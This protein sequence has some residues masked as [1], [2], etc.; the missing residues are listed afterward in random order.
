MAIFGWN[1]GPIRGASHVSSGTPC[2]DSVC[3]ACAPDYCIAAVSDG[4]GGKRYF[5]SNIGSRFAVNIAVDLIKS[6]FESSGDFVKSLSFSPDSILG[7]LEKEILQTWFQTVEDYDRDHPL[8]EDEY[9]YAEANDLLADEPIKR[10]GCTL[11]VSVLV[12]SYSFSL[13]I[14]DGDILALYPDGSVNMPVPTDPRCHDNVTTSMCGSTASE[15]F[16]HIFLSENLPAGIMLSSD[17][18]STSFSSES[19]FLKYG[20]NA[21]V[22]CVKNL[23]QNLREDLVRRSTIVNCDDVSCAILWNPDMTVKAVNDV[24]SEYSGYFSHLAKQHEKELRKFR[25]SVAYVPR[26]R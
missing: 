11:L 26:K 20:R 6:K 24:D 1:S 10:Y 15:D 23:Q 2:Q 7:E 22:Y 3:T 19:K 5:R 8:S 4:H 16:R 14:G 9:R 13:Q 12:E 17:G 25:K 21:I 18:V